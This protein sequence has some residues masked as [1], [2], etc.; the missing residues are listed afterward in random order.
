MRRILWPAI[1]VVLCLLFWWVNFGFSADKSVTFA[2]EQDANDLP[3][4]KEWRI[5]KSSAPGGPYETFV[6]VPYDGQAKPTYTATTVLT[7]P[8]GQKTTLYFVATAVATSG[9]ES[10]PSNECSYTF[11]FSTVTVPIRLRI[12]VS[13]SGQ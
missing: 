13:P 5:K 4:L 6:V 11:D 8:S 9:F 7:V 1:I 3:V 2:W 10:G 12:E